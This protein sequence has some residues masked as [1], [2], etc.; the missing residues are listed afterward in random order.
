MTGGCGSPAY[1]AAKHAALGLARRGA[2]EL[3]GTQ[4]RVNCVGPG[5]TRT[6]LWQNSR[7]IGASK[8]GISATPATGDVH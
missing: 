6:A 8:N 5:V 1:T 3:A 2:I 7:D 4:I